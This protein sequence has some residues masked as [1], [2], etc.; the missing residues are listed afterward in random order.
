M[1][2][3]IHTQWLAAMCPQEREKALKYKQWELAATGY[4]PSLSQL[5]K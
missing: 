2:R 1:L 3:V 4:D 5:L